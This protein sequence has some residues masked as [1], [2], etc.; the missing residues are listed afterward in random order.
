LMP[1]ANS[2]VADA[3]PPTQ[4]AR[5]MGFYGIA[6]YLGAGL[7]LI[8]G[9]VVI[10]L[11]TGAAS[12]A[13]H[14]AP[15]HYVLMAV[16]APGFLIALVLLTLREP[17]RQERSPIGP[18]NAIRQGR[19]NRGVLALHYSSFGLL[20]TGSYATLAWGPSHLIRFYGMT[21]PQAGLELGLAVVIGGCIGILTAS[22]LAD[23][24]AARG[25]HEAKFTIPAV[26]ALLGFLA[27]LLPLVRPGAI[28]FVLAFG[29]MTLAVSAGVGLAPAA[30]GAFVPNERRG[31]ALAGYQLTAGGVA[32]AVGAPLVAIVSQHWLGGDRAVGEA[33]SLVAAVAFAL[34]AL[35]LFVGRKAFGRAVRERIAE[36]SFSLADS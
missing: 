15:W 30:I 36:T 21:R 14:L 25:R 16:G 17:E 29:L 10:A 4:R 11:V 2:I 6:I 27:A 23:A 34:A 20:A 18:S 3:F 7:A 31:R 9:G 22:S 5:A 32:G 1:G 33:L 19:R 12:G 28:T 24:A 26:F 35:I 13:G 8:F